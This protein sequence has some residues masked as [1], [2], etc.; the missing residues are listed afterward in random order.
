[1]NEREGD[2]NISLICLLFILLACVWELHKRSIQA[3]WNAGSLFKKKALGNLGSLEPTER[4]G[5]PVS[6][7]PLGL[8]VVDKKT[9]D[10][11]KSDCLR[12]KNGMIL[13]VRRGHA[14]DDF[15]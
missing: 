13:S 6:L 9:E 11:G 15:Q 14:M 2:R 7:G 1:M 5:R 4:G 8:T 12:A 10:K 3:F